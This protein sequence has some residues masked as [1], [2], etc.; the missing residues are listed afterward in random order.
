MGGRS[1]TMV[2]LA[3]AAGDTCLH[4]LLS[5]LTV[6]TCG[7]PNTPGGSKPSGRTSNLAPHNQR[8]GTGDGR[9]RRL[10]APPA[11]DGRLS[12]KTMQ[13]FQVTRPRSSP[14]SPK[15]VR[16]PGPPA[17][18][19]PG[20]ALP[21]RSLRKGAW[22]PREGSTEPRRAPRAAAPQACQLTSS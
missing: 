18:A 20:D 14:P 10:P 21:P 13:H 19:P 8:E 5:M 6:I 22:S 16:S 17:V 9:S 15:S 12:A 11:T 1:T 3:R 2:Q 4:V 7:V